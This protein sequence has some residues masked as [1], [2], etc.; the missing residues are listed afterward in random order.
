MRRIT[1]ETLVSVIIP[2]YNRQHYVR[3]CLLTCKDQTHRPI[4]IIV[5]D[6]GSTDESQKV[7]NE[8]FEQLKVSPGISV[9]YFHQENKG[10]PSARN[11]GLTKATGSFIKFM[12]SDDLLPPT[13]LQM[14]LNGFREGVDVVFGNVVKIDPTSHPVGYIDYKGFNEKEQ[15]ST[16][17][18]QSI[19][20]GCL[21][22]RKNCFDEVRFDETIQ[23]AQDRELCV[24]LLVH[25]FKFMHIPVVT[26]LHRIPGL[27]SISSL[28]WTEK[29]P[30]RYIHSFDT[31]LSY[32]KDC[33]EKVIRKS[34]HGI[35]RSLWR[36]ARKLL[37]A[38]K[39][40]EASFYYSHAIKINDGEIP[41]SWF[42]RF[43]A[44]LI[45]FI[46]I[47]RFKVLIKPR[48]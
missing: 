43:L 46:T 27:D 42:Y 2:V 6:D 36:L 22:F 38:R 16:V 31:I 10:A 33:D 7:I 26:Y 47:E 21:M 40:L 17:A 18:G 39:N 15:I 5:V 35:A 24:N 25:G 19:L 23:V 13:A 3:Q 14:L 30:Y 11:L 37:T 20:T 41:K 44:I 4:E 8:A 29:N 12:D 9:S 1:N 48:R 32:V 28:S 34:K 45:P